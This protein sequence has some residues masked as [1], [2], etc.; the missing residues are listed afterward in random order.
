MNASKQTNTITSTIQTSRGL[1]PIKHCNS[2]ETNNATEGR[3]NLGWYLTL[4]R[5]VQGREI[6]TPAR[7]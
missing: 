2:N 1:L 7:L 3:T 5:D 6:L 4:I